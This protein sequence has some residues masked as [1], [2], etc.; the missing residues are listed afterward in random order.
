M[1]DYSTALMAALRLN[2]SNL[3]A[4]CCEI[5]PLS[6]SKHF[7]ISK[8][9][10]IYSL[11]ELVCRSLTLLYA[12]RLL[13]WISQGEVVWNSPHIHFYMVSPFLQIEHSNKKARKTID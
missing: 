3:V 7:T 11:V 1:S 5:T 13:K 6:Q 2:D 9:L 12:E 4:R 8:S 10:I